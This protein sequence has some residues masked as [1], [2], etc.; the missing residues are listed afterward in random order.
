MEGIL[1]FKFLIMNTEILSKTTSEV[2]NGKVSSDIAGVY[3]S[4]FAQP[5]YNEIF[6]LEEATINL[7][8][9]INN[10]GDLLIRRLGNRTIALA[11]G[12]P[13]GDGSYWIEELAV[14]PDFQG[15]GVGR[16]MLR[17]LLTTV[18]GKNIKSIGLRTTANNT[19][20]LGLYASEGFAVTGA[21]VIVASKRENGHLE[22]DERVYLSKPLSSEPMKEKKGIKRLTVMYPSGNTTA[23]VFDQLLGQDRKELNNSIMSQWK[24]DY[25]GFPEI[26]QCCFV[27]LPKSPEAIARVEMFGGE[28]CGNATRS[29]IYALTGGNDYEGLIEVSGVARPLEFKIENEEVALEMPLPEELG[30]EE[31]EEGILVQLD[32]IAQLVVIDPKEARTPAQLLRELKN[33]AKYDL[34]TQP[35]VGVSYYDT[36]TSSTKFNVWVNAIDTVFDET[37]CGSGTCAIGVAIATK[38][39]E[40]ITLSVIQP[41]GKTIKVNCIWD[42]IKGQVT[43]AEIIGK[44]Q[45]LYNGPFSL[46]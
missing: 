38:R 30:I 22:L 32:G 6:T 34:N 45:I 29:V 23:I 5:P 25:A 7:S 10:G 40:S 16:Q 44:V 8:K 26:E 31:V 20:A 19:K 35:A 12:V 13:Q 39:R 43:R 42:D 24:A 28:F 17:D 1:F 15:K 21:P 4:A 3:Q 2:V 41:S 14:E 27:T 18:A 11:G 36:T 9:L 46:E 33:Q 37:A